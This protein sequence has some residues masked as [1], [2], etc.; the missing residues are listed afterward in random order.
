MDDLL[1]AVRAYMILGQLEGR[2]DHAPWGMGW[3]KVP[4]IDFDVM[5]G[6]SPVALPSWGGWFNAKVGQF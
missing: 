1:F 4:F 2:T 3:R 6:T 5:L